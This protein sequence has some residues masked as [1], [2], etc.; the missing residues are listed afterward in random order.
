MSALNTAAKV[1]SVSPVKLAHLVL[2]TGDVSAMRDWYLNVLGAEV[3]HETKGVPRLCFVTFDEEHHRIAFVEIPGA[4]RAPLEAAGIEHISF[5]YAS[6]GD[7]LTTYQR[8]RD[9]GIKPFWTIH[10]GPTISLYYFDPDQNRVELQV[11]TM[12]SEGATG[13]INSDSYGGNPIGVIF[14]V[15]E[16]VKDYDRGVDESSL[17][18]PL[19][20]PEGKSPLDM[21]R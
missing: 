7:L 2:K 3:K 17:F 12:T 1:Q 6:L 14:D 19:P 5:T 21:I 11:D 9:D 8:L 15:E 18:K 13:Y 10:H 4:Q 20:L 16:L